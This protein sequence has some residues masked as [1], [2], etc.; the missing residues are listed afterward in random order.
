[1]PITIEGPDG[2]GKVVCPNIVEI[3][4]RYREWAEAHDAAIALEDD[5]PATAMKEVLKCML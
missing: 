3:Y 2:A 1:M 4:K 5:N